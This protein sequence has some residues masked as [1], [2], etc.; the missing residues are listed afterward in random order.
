M[1]APCTSTSN[2]PSQEPSLRFCHSSVWR[3]VFV[4]LSTLLANPGTS[5]S[6]TRDERMRRTPWVSVHSRTVTSRWFMLSYFATVAS[7]SRNIASTASTG[8][9]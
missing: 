3:I 4:G 8:A 1:G 5:T 2:V 6:T 9:L 7:G